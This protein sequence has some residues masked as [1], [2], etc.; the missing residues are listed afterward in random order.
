MIEVFLRLSKKDKYFLR[1][2]ENIF[3][4]INWFVCFY[5]YF[6]VKRKRLFLVI[7]MIFFWFFNTFDIKFV[8]VIFL[9]VCYV[10]K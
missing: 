7:G 8:L 9:S 10:G 6:L 4:K 3:L 1:L 5:V 2:K